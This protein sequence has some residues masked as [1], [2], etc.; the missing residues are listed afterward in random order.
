VILVT[1]LCSV[2]TG[3]AQPTNPTGAAVFDFQKR[4]TAYVDLHNREAG[5]VSP[6]KETDSPAQIST[7]ERQLGEAIKAARAGAA[8]GALFG[9]VAGIVRDV[10]RTDWQHRSPAER[11][12]MMV[13][14]PK[15]L[16]ARPDTIYPTTL[17][18]ATCPPALL[19]ALPRLPHELEY[20]FIGRH[21]ILRD[22]DANLVVD[23]LENALPASS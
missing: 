15:G 21:L 11:K 13:E 5:K 12:A 17:P 7:R 4:V 14:V 9:P 19:Q 18:L 3:Q 10:I 16:S 2:P 1:L 8:A 20:R 22:V 6:L 23:V